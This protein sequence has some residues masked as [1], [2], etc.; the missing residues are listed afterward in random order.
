MGLRGH[1]VAVES[2]HA[3]HDEQDAR[4]LWQAS[5][6]LTGVRYAPQDTAPKAVHRKAGMCQER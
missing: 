4:R 6:E 3:L 1:P 2:S 5:E